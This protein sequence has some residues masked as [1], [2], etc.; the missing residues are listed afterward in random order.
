MVAAV[1]AKQRILRFLSGQS[2]TFSLS[3]PTP[4]SPSLFSNCSN[5][6]FLPSTREAKGGNLE[7]SL[8]GDGW[9]LVKGKM[10]IR[11]RSQVGLCLVTHPAVRGTG[12]ESGQVRLVVQGTDSQETREE[13]KRQL[14]L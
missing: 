8:E 7:V 3:S 9:G 12:G 14:G 6:R 1:G 11:K 5:Q 10:V 2:Q 13:E 4:I